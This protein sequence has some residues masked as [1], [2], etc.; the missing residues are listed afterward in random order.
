MVIQRWQS[1]LLL[2]AVVLMCIFCAT[3]YAHIHAVEA[4]AS[5]TPVFVYEAPVFLIINI[6]IVLLL[7]IAIFMYKNLRRQMTVTIISMVL[8]CASIVTGAFILYSTMPD[9]E[10]VWAGGVVLLIVALICAMAAYRF[11]RKDRNLLRS[12]DRLR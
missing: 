3:P 6:V 9:A 7:F 4:A 8:I 12:Y 2:I 1:L 10:L 11:M 5:P